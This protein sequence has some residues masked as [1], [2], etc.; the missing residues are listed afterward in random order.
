MAHPLPQTLPVPDA[1]VAG[2]AVVAFPQLE[3]IVMN[4]LKYAQRIAR[5]FSGLEQVEESCQRTE[6]LGAI[7]GVTVV[8]GMAVFSSDDQRVKFLCDQDVL[9]IWVSRPQRHWE[10][11]SLEVSRLNIGNIYWR[12]DNIPL[13][14]KEGAIMTL[15]SE[16]ILELLMTLAEIAPLLDVSM[17]ELIRSNETLVDAYARHKQAINR[18]QQG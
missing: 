12:E 14:V 7:L 8:Q 18:R 6:D 16:D 4:H 11:L 9:T 3:R 5:Y 15:P 17:E 10:V 13:V 1:F 2:D